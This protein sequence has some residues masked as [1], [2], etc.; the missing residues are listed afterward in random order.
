MEQP[1]KTDT[2]NT[3][4]IRVVGLIF[5]SLATGVIRI[6]TDGKTIPQWGKLPATAEVTTTARSLIPSNKNYLSPDQIRRQAKQE[7]DRG[8]KAV[9]ERLTG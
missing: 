2:R 7:G 8:I 3:Q 4:E 5:S 1:P 6:G 9:I